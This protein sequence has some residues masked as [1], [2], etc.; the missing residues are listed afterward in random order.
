MHFDHVGGMEDFPKVYP[1][2]KFYVQ[3]KEYDFWTGGNVPAGFA[4]DA[5]N[6]SRTTV[7]PTALN[8]Q[9]RIVTARALTGLGQY[10][11]ALEMLGSD[12]SADAT[13][14]RAEVVWRQKN[15]PQA[16]AIF[17][18]MLG[19]RYKT[20]GPLSSIEEGQ[21]LRSAVAYSLAADD[22]SLARLRERWTPFVAG[23]RNPDALRVAM[24]G[25]NGDQVSP[26]D[27][28]RIAADN[29]VF[30]GWVSKMKD[31]F[32]QAPPPAPHPPQ[33][34]RQ[35]EVDVAPTGKAKPA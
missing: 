26:P 8:V 5:I 31:R 13:D 27:L 7:L 11:A 21:L 30:E 16:G 22:V 34:T 2:A 28:S 18:R 4:L 25:L 29:Q 9:R 10:D 3:K 35:A 17:E 14:A 19:D 24:S 23:A 33:T 12:S 1:N 32:R 15:W 20:Q 6:E